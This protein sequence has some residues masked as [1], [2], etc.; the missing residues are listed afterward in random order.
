M[1]EPLIVQTVRKFQ[2]ALLRGEEEQ[3]AEMA[4]RWME[5]ERTLDGQLNALALE[6]ERA[7]RGGMPIS[8]NQIYQMERY[9]ALLAQ[10]QTEIRKYEGYAESLIGARQ[11]E[12]LGSGWEN[13]RE[14][15]RQAKPA[16]W[17][18]TGYQLPAQAM[19]NMVGMLA[20]GS[21]LNTL[22]AQA[23]VDGIDGLT[24]ALINSMAQGWNA[25]KTAQAMAD[26]LAGG[27][28]R[29]L[30]IART[31][32]LRAYRLANR[33]GY[34][35][36]GLVQRYKRIAAKSTR[37][38]IACILSDGKTYDVKADF[39]EH[40]AGRCGMVPVI[41]GLDEP[42]WES[43]AEWL[44]KQNEATQREMMGDK[45]FSAWR[46]GQITLDDMVTRHEDN[47]WGAYLKPTPFKN[48]VLGKTTPTTPENSPVGPNGRLVS[49]ALNLNSLRNRQMRSQAELV[50]AEINK[51]HGDGALPTIP[52]NESTARNKYGAFWYRN[53]T[54][55]KITLSRGGDH[56]ALTLAHEIGH[57]LDLSALDAKWSSTRTGTEAQS[58]INAARNSDWVK[59]VWTRVSE[60]NS[61][62]SSDTMP[63]SIDSR[64][65]RYLLETKEIWARAYAQYVATKSGNETL[66]E[67]LRKLQ[68]AKFPSQWSD[69]DFLP[70]MAEFDRLFTKKGWIE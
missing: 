23:S 40:P 25:R 2:A 26:G 60:F 10:A 35:A 44:M 19:Q 36:S 70:I 29:A 37:T 53:T 67:Q 15:I 20:S 43:G 61:R 54:P 32:Q 52:V 21:P 11:K 18:E 66:L 38:C 57:F 48:L 65:V 28:D 9:Q 62:S 50:L 39:E 63:I 33:M 4:K 16:D 58:V 8:R 64:Y 30:L 56:Q 3:F 12:L 34:E 6:I 49:E 41:T 7:A 31:E 13:A 55:E 51:I 1:S 14:I 22:L 47:T 42:N 27:L 69:D 59:N 5:V 45:M 17:V 24:Q 68:T 46:A